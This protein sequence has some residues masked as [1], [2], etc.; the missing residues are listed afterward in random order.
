MPSHYDENT[1]VFVY[2]TLMKG[3]SNHALLE[4]SEMVAKGEIN[5]R[6]FDA[7]SFP[8]LV[9]PDHSEENWASQTVRG[10]V[11][12]VDQKTLDRLDILEGHP[13]LYVRK[14][15]AVKT[16][17]PYAWM[18]C[19]VYYWN[20]HRLLDQIT[21]GDYRKHLAHRTIDQF[22]AEKLASR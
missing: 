19:E 3:L 1:Y 15:I 7:G 11:Y 4:N 6:V 22:L 5:G 8:A 21:H 2:G 18:R 16:G 14:H 10:E 9:P 12:S 17:K 13:N 20:S